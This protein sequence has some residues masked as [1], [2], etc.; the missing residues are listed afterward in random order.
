VCFFCDIQGGPKNGLLF[1]TVSD[2]QNYAFHSRQNSETFDVL[3]G[4]LS[5]V[6]AKLSDLKNSP[7]FGPLCR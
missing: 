6:I 2:M 4:F 1:E 7:F 5:S 3:H